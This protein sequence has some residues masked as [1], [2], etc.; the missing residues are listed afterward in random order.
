MTP[1]EW[2]MCGVLVALAIGKGVTVCLLRT[3]QRDAEETRR[4]LAELLSR[5]DARR[6]QVE[7]DA[8]RDGSP[9]SKTMWASEQ[10]RAYRARKAGGQS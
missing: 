7:K 8:V 6:E 4:T 3:V 5:D 2:T 1:F 10:L 9:I